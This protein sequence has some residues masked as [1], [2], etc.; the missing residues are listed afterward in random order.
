MKEEMRVKTVSMP[1]SLFDKLKKIAEYEERSVNSVICR[2]VK[3][4]MEV[5]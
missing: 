4:G 3:K 1:K 5:K 2:L